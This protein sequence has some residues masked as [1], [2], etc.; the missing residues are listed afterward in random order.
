MEV[1]K[2]RAQDTDQ[3][4]CKMVLEQKKISYLRLGV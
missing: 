2:F 4:N 3:E 1:D